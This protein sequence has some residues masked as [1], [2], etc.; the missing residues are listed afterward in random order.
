MSPRTKYRLIL[1]ILTP[2]AWLPF[3]FLYLISDLI[4]LIVYHV[5]GYRK[6]VVRN[7][8]TA[9]FPDRTPREIQQIEREFYR[10]LSDL[11]VETVKL[12]HFTDRQVAQRIETC[13]YEE[14]NRTSADGRPLFIF[15]G[16]YGDWEWVPAVTLHCRPGIVCGQIYRQQRNVAMDWVMLRIRSRFGTFSLPQAQAFRTIL[17]RTRAGEQLLM[18]FIADQRPNSANLNHWT[19]FLHQDTAYAPGGEEIGRRVNAHYYYLD[20]E[21]KSRGHYRMTFRPIVPDADLR[22]SEYPYTL[23]FMRML[24]AT[25]K[26]QPAYW[27]W[28]HKRWSIKRLT[29]D[30]NANKPIS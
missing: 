25:I 13:G 17:R 21:K 16:H 8:L 4:Y 7:N 1:G 12:L 20:V 28:S 15:L 23:Q 9:A 11:I 3:W 10:H 2:L 6:H 22:D 26:R 30:D 19:E 18:G 24:Q 29:A 14:L 27:L 5:V